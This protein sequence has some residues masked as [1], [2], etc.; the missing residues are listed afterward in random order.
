MKANHP[1]KLTG[2]VGHVG[3]SAT[4]LSARVAEV[5]LA[6]IRDGELPARSRLP[7][8]E[9]LGK[10]FG[11]SRTVI[12]EA[13]ASLRAAGM[14]TTRH[15]IGAFVRADGEAEPDS[16]TV[17]VLTRL[18][19]ESLLNIIEVRRGLE[20]ETA[21]L[22]AARRS[23]EQLADIRMALE[24]LSLATA[25][26]SDGVEE[27]VGFHLAIARATGNP[28]WVALVESYAQQI[29]KAVRVTRANESRR[30]DFARQV[31]LEHE[32]IVAAIADRNSSM[33]RKAATSHMEHAARRVSAADRDFWQAEGG[34][35]ARGLG[36][37]AAPA[38]K[39]S[40]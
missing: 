29:G 31:R 35:L 5:V 30:D 33:A 40:R 26:G 3:H 7:S 36:H 18:S 37:D 32:R 11:V 16:A 38:A 4:S 17:D 20:A 39:S 9:A 10:H 13:M 28:Y 27:D 34:E 2:N 12:R 25:R 8:E 6:K 14:I 22:A 21:A 15:G 1:F 23:E 19:I 24:R